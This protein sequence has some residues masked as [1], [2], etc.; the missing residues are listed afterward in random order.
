MNGMTDATRWIESDDTHP[1]DSWSRIGSGVWKGMLSGLAGVAVMTAGEKVEQRLTGRPDSFM[2]AHTLERLLRLP[3]RPDQQRVVLNAAMHVGQ[4]VL[5]GAWRGVMAEGG[6]R[7]WRASSAFTVIRLSTDQ[8]LENVTG[9]GAPPWTWPRRELAV[10][11]VHKTVYAFTTGFV[12]DRL[13]ARTPAWVR[14]RS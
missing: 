10:D 13:T 4:A 7:G 6:L 3:Q 8:T 9:Q 1:I 11:V 14:A 2:P 5:V 12:A